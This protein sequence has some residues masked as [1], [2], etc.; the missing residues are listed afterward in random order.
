MGCNTLIIPPRSEVYRIIPNIKLKEDAVLTQK[1]RKE[2][3]SEIQYD[4][5]QNVNSEPAIIHNININHESLSN[6]EISSGYLQ[7]KEKKVT[8]GTENK[9]VTHTSYLNLVD[10]AGSEKHDSTGTMGARKE[11]YIYPQTNA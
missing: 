10:L 8:S 9:G 11:K 3:L 4:N 2:F 6:F 5:R 1:Q 7:D